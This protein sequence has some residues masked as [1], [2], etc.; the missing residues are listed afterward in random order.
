MMFYFVGW[1]SQNKSTSVK[2]SDVGTY[3]FPIQALIIVLVN[4]VQIYF[5]EKVKKRSVSCTIV[6]IKNLSI[7]DLVVGIMVLLCIVFKRVAVVYCPDS[8]IML[9][10]TTFLEICSLRFSLCTS[11]AILTIFPV[12]K[13]L[14]VTKN[15]RYTQSTAQT[16]C[17]TAWVACVAVTL[18]GYIV[19]RLGLIPTTNKKYEY[20]FYPV[21]THSLT[22]SL[23]RG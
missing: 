12:I 14:I 17:N 16:I 1:T 5:L 3:T 21:L 22:H 20:L 11:V 19:S 10:I 6:F 13:M 8:N 4:T 23:T 9:E 18:P 2:V 7:T 15:K